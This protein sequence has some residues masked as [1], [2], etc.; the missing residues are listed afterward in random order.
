MRKISYLVFGTFLAASLFLTQA[1]AQ[2]QDRFVPEPEPVET[3]EEVEVESETETRATDYNSSR[4]N[5]TTSAVIEI[6]TDSDDEEETDDGVMRATDYNS[7]RSNR[8]TSTAIE[9]ED[10]G[11][12]EENSDSALYRAKAEPEVRLDAV[13]DDVN[14]E[15]IQEQVQAV[16]PTVEIKNEAPILIVNQDGEMV[17]QVPATE[18]RKM[19]GL[20]KINLNV[21][22]EMDS[23]GDLIQINRP[24]YSFLSW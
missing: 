1:W 8:T 20:F 12:D 11:D 10:T 19:F 2:E 7:S 3:V 6:E 9:I 15:V 22:V 18:P 21:Q 17:T 23:E 5:R 24:W 4:S 16:A 13:L 14:L